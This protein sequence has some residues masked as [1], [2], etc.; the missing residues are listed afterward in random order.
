MSR[1]ELD[2]GME[3]RFLLLTLFLIQCVEQAEENKN[4]VQ[5]FELQKHSLVSVLTSPF[6][7]WTLV[8]LPQKFSLSEMSA[9]SQKTA[10][11]S[12]C[13]ALALAPFLKEISTPEFQLG[14]H[15]ETS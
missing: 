8:M 10:V 11:D 5:I 14:G 15:G 2:F 6:S 7:W 13:T 9:Q 3:R 12:D 4:P 1:G